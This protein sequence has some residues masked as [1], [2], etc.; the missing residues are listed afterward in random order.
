MEEGKGNMKE[1]DVIVEILGVEKSYGD[2]K[3]L[4]GVQFQM[5]RGKI[6]GLVGRNGSGKTVLM[7]CILGI[8]RP[9]CGSII[10]RGREIGKDIEFAQNTGFLIERP[11]FFEDWNGYENLKYFMGIRHKVD[12]DLI[13]RCMEEVGLGDVGKKKVGKYSMGMKQRLGIAQ[14]LMEQPDLLI[15][16]EPMNG[17]DNS[18]VAEIRSK[19]LEWKEKGVTILLA[20]HNREDIEYL[21]DQE[22]ELDRG[23]WSY[24]KI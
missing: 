5:E 19:L 7:K 22:Y 23:N 9:D 8:L 2:Q 16:D 18:G 21:C 10:I 4:N 17:L 15:L 6:Y 1:K 20:S 24:V 13:Y 3:V 12:A 14:A 11:G